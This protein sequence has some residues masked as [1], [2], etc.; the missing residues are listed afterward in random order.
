MLLSNA[1]QMDVTMRIFALNVSSRSCIVW[2]CSVGNTLGTVLVDTWQLAG[3][4]FCH[5]VTNMLVGVVSDLVKNCGSE[6]W[7]D[8]VFVRMDL[9]VHFQ[10]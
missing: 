4:V 3:S 1:V 7:T 2:Y 8:F 9:G 6:T 10:R 5:N